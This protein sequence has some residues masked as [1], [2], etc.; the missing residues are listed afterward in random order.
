MTLIIG[1]RKEMNIIYEFMVIIHTFRTN[2]YGITLDK[3]PSIL[4][5]LK[6][7]ILDI[8]TMQRFSKKTHYSLVIYYSW[9]FGQI[10][11]VYY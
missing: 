2:P 4:K 11:T 9:K 8:Y 1:N 6:K 10:F 7:N 5:D 3:T